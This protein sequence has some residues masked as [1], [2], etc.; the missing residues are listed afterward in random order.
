MDLVTIACE[1]DIQDLLLQAHSID[2]FIETPCRHWITIE[3]NSL[4]PEQW[5][6]LLS[7]YYQRHTLHLKFST[8]P[9]LI[10]DEP[11]NLGYRRQQI[12]KLK[13]AAEVFEERVLV[14][15]CKNIFI[16]PTDLNA[17]PYKSGVGR[18]TSLDTEP[19]DFF[20]RQ[21][22]KYIH[23]KTGLKIP[24]RF[25]PTL[26]T[27]F[28]VITEY[29]RDAVKHPLFESLFY[30]KDNVFPMTEMFYYQFFVPEKDIDGEKE[31]I[32]SAV[33]YYDI[34]DISDCDEHFNVMIYYCVDVHNSPTHGLHRKVRLH[35]PMSAKHIYSDWLKRLGLDATLVDN[36]VYFMAKDA[37]WGL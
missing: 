19:E 28:V 6:N 31:T 1:R 24:D 9:D 4:T 14:L 37:V 26:A 2:K 36:Y 8:R 30:N 33:S 12:L 7:P 16:R 35:V 10:F 13:A 27:P 23:E 15:D 18:F 21:W 34:P 11:F 22:I 5:Y 20:P 3:D 32:C 25:P 17:W 29:A